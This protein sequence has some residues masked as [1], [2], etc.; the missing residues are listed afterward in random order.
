MRKKEDGRW[1]Q[2]CHAEARS[3]RR[4]GARAPIS[5]AASLYQAMYPV[6]HMTIAAG[7]VW[8]GAWLWRRLVRR[9]PNAPGPAQTIDYRF[10]VFGALVPD[11]IDKPLA[12]LGISGFTYG[13]TSGHTIGHTL[14][15]SFCVLLAGTLIAR[16]GDLRMLVLGLGAL[17]HPLVD[18]T[19]T[20]PQTLVWPL[21]GT[22]F[23]HSHQDY[24]SYFQLP[25]E[26]LLIATYAVPVWRSECWRARAQ[27][28][29]RTGVFPFANHEPPRAAPGA[30]RL[31]TQP[32]GPTRTPPV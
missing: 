1:W 17:T 11:L 28:F 5:A 19:N 18:P 26:I 14:L 7:S 13:E 6:T 30:S 24:R 22:D 27:A 32:A 10:A 21:F 20:Y 29:V 9:A 25:L 3:I 16:R 15:V 8:A 31:S 2:I 12:K 23:P 4:R